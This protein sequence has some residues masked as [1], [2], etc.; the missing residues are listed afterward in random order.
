MG[1]IQL[2]SVSKKYGK[3]HA[4]KDVDL[5]I[6]DGEFLVLL[7]P[8]GCGKS[9]L[10]RLVAGLIQP[11]SGRILLDDKDITA[12]PPRNRDL[13]MVF[14]SYALYPHLSVAKNIGFPLRSRKF[15]RTV[16]ANSVAAVASTLDLSELLDR[17]P[18]ELSGGQRQRVALARAMVRDPGAFLMDEPLSNLDAKL[19]SATRSELIE[20]HRRIGTTFLYVTHDQVEAMTMATRIALMD[21]GHIEQIG[22]PAELYDTPRSTFV[23]GFLGA[24]PM[25]L[26]DAIVTGC[27]GELHAVAPGID[28]PLGIE[29]DSHS[30]HPVVA[31]IRP[32]KMQIVDTQ[33]HVE[34]VIATVENLGSEEL[35]HVRA[36]A[37]PLSIRVPRPSTARAGAP[38]SIRVNPADVHLFDRDSG[39]RLRW[40]PEEAP[41]RTGTPLYVA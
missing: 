2:E 39:P 3:T 40:S 36:G 6:A 32:E 26:F 38:I 24:P 41:A 13:A 5:D 16:I 25:N 30:E 34:A 10:L 33:A 35:V 28:I 29:A 37:N 1:R 14:Q 17:R 11:S 31:G 21:N 4:L 15:S 18:A 9:T 23:A 20:L 27:R 12:T 19:R 22:T 8:S 7:G